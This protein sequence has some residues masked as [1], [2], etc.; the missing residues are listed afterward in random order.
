MGR[1]HA[2]SQV[3]AED[4]GDE[5]AFAVDAQPVEHGLDVVLDGGRGDVQLPGDLAGRETG[6]ELPGGVA[7]ARGEPGAWN[8]SGATPAASAA[9]MV[10]ATDPGGVAAPR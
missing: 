1:P 9:W 7:L 4:A 10:T 3:P 2:P 6:E 8:T 5:L